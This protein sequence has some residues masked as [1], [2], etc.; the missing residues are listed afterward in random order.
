[1]L[2][3]PTIELIELPDGYYE[4]KQE[5]TIMSNNLKFKPGEEFIDRRPM[6]G[7]KKAVIV[8]DGE[9]RLVQTSPDDP[10]LRVTTQFTDNETLSV[11]IR[12]LQLMLIQLARGR[13]V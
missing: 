13:Q 11:I 9:N 5:T 8:F 1:M 7:D 3:S 12:Y 10:S 6:A 2:L 4:L